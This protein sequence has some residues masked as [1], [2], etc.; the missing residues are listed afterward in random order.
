MPPF[1]P[2]LGN[3][4][5]PLTLESIPSITKT[6]LS[7]AGIECFFRAAGKLRQMAWTHGGNKFGGDHQMPPSIK[8]CNIHGIGI[9]TYI[10]HKNQPNVGKY[11]IHGSYGK[12]PETCLPS[13][14]IIAWRKSVWKMNF[15]FWNGL[16]TGAMSVLD[17]FFTWTWGFVSLS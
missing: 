14:N 1:P 15:L 12:Y 3:Q 13:T 7:P 5:Q 2:F 10:Y 8:T 4:K 9:F 16:L 6:S 17:S 11:T